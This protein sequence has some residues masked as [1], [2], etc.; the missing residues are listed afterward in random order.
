MIAFSGWAVR[1]PP[2][3]AAWAL[4]LAWSRTALPMP[5]NARIAWGWRRRASM[6]PGLRTKSGTAALPS[7]LLD[8][9][10]GGLGAVL[11]DVV[12]GL[13]GLDGGVLDEVTDGVGE[14]TGGGVDGLD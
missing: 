1:A 5:R 3:L 14:D 2:R 13:E 7:V 8:G 4:V 9:L 12:L 11:G 10:G 6:A